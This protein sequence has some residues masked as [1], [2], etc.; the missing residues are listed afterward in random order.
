MS[1]N[2]DSY[3]EGEDIIVSLN[4][5]TPALEDIRL[6]FSIQSLDNFEDYSGD[7]FVNILKGKVSVQILDTE[8]AVLYPITVFGERA[9]MLG[10]GAS[11][12]CIATE[13]CILA[14]LSRAAFN[15]AIGTKMAQELEDLTRL[16]AVVQNSKNERNYRASKENRISP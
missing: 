12:S 10:G 9:L 16:R 6:G 13:P 7:Q 15:A 5:E 4:L 8:V 14:S 2:K 11:A 3:N 1:T